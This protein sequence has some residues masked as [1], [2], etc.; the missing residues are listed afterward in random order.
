MG[1]EW[2]QLQSISLGE[3]SQGFEDTCKAALQLYAIAGR[4]VKRLL[5]RQQYQVVAYAC[6]IAGHPLEG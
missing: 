4:E 3:S 2:A 1:S 5:N 6:K